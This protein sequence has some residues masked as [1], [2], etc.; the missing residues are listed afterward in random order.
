[1]KRLRNKQ[2]GIQRIILLVLGVM[3]TAAGITG[4]FLAYGSTSLSQELDPSSTLL[5]SHGFEFFDQHTREV[6]VG[7]L[8]VALLFVALSLWWLELQI[9][10]RLR[11]DN[12][13][14]TTSD[15]TVTPG[16][17]VVTGDALARAFENDLERSPDVTRARAEFRLS[18][19]LIRLRL[20]LHEGVDIHT[21]LTSTLAKAIERIS[22]VSEMPRMP[23]VET[24]IRLVQMQRVLT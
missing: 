17:N 18:D 21:L 24:D 16:T 10:P 13:A 12:L 20:D 5:N 1:M 7:S 22:L 2:L 19:D 23:R 8:L 4:L 15:A 6:R 11:Q 9:P 14:Y 3:L